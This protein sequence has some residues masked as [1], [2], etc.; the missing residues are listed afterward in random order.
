MRYVQQIWHHRGGKYHVVLFREGRTMMIATVF[1]D[2]GNVS[3]LKRD[4]L[5]KGIIENGYTDMGV[6]TWL[7]D[8][9]ATYGDDWPKRKAKPA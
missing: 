5:A 9:I 3:V 4:P 1:Q 7:R 2:R 6:E 8:T